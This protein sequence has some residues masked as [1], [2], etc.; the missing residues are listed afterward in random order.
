MQEKEEQLDLETGQH[1]ILTLEEMNL[2]QGWEDKT[3]NPDNV[4]T[5]IEANFQLSIHNLETTN[6]PTSYQ[7]QISH[8][9]HQNQADQDIRRYRMSPCN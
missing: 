1:K 3:V 5:P 8:Q 7:G 4:K 9:L 6:H 2:L